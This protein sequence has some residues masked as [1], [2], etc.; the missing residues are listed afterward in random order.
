MAKSLPNATIYAL[1]ISKEAIQIA[2]ENAKINDVDINFIESDVLNLNATSLIVKNLKFDVI[3]SN[4]P[5]VREQEKPLMKANVVNNEPHLALF[6]TDDNP[7]QFYKAITVLAMY[8]L[9]TKGTLFFEIN[10]YFGKDMIHLLKEHNF[11]DIELKQDFFKKDR[12]IKG[13]KH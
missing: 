2:N 11:S 8:N 10:E 1:D 6:V 5:Y 3:V 13:V 12:M 7:L 4:P 9:N